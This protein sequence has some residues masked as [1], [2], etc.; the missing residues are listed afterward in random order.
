MSSSADE[1]RAAIQAA[2]Q[3]DP[4]DPMPA[5]EA[6]VGAIYS[7]ARGRRHWGYAETN[8]VCLRRYDAD[9]AQLSRRQAG[10]F[11]EWIRSG[12]A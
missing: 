11:I 7:S 9:P 8:G 10:D 5:T 12:E 2:P 6:Q 4:H 1:A 3:Y